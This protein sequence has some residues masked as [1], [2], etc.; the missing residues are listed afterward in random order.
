MGPA[1]NTHT[2]NETV[3]PSWKQAAFLKIQLLVELLP[4]K[5]ER[6]FLKKGKKKR[7]SSL[8]SRWRLRWQR[9][10]HWKKRSP[11]ENAT[12]LVVGLSKKQRQL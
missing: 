8:G 6:F 1:R 10:R 4:Q 9:Q 11:E 3:L 12:K 7:K 2:N 5:S